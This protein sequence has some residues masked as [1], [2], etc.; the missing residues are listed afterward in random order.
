MELSFENSMKKVASDHHVGLLLVH[1]I[2]NQNFDVRSMVQQ[3]C[4][5]VLNMH[6]KNS[7]LGI[8]LNVLLSQHFIV[9]HMSQ[10][11]VLSI[12]IISIVGMI[13]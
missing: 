6:W 2:R 10:V 7:F 9:A 4:H 1:R 12:L 3:F 13:G 8:K 5:N 11:D